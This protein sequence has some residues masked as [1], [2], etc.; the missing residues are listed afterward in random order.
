MKLMKLYECEVFYTV[1]DVRNKPEKEK[2]KITVS[3]PK[4]HLLKNPSTPVKFSK[5]RHRQK[6]KKDLKGAELP[7]KG[8]K[9]RRKV[10][11]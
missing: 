11:Y 5:S 3:S 2:H 10:R 1:K 4:L 7:L 6:V 8:H 9:N